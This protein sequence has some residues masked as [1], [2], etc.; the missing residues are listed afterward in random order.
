[1]T[2][3][4]ICIVGDGLAGATAAAA[5]S[6]AGFDCALIGRGDAAG[7][8]VR[9]TALMP[10]TV[11]LLRGCGVWDHAA[12]TAY[13]LERMRIIDGGAVVDFTAEEVGQPALAWNVPN[14]ALRAAGL[15]AADAQGVTRVTGEAIGIQRRNGVATVRLGDGGGIAAELV[16]AAD[17]E[18]SRMRSAAGVSA[19]RWDYGLSALT[20]PVTAQIDP[21]ATSVERYLPT[22]S[23]TTV[24]TGD[25]VSIVWIADHETTAERDALNDWDL[26]KDAAAAVDGDLGD[27]R[28]AGPRARF[29][30][31]GLHAR[32]YGRDGVALI[33]EA[34]HRVP[35]L[36][37]QGFNLTARDVIG[38]R[39]ALLDA[40]R[41]GV[42]LGA[43]AVLSRYDRARRP[44]VTSRI[45]AVD[46]LTR[47]VSAKDGRPLALLRGAG[48][49][50]LGGSAGAIRRLLMREGM[51]P[52]LARYA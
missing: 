14:A 29:P 37:S 50:M 46:A 51:E 9:T 30:L 40:R 7:T 5:L 23:I 2:T 17:G 6:A 28:I 10:E 35:P 21:G 43:S 16:I 27:L 36:G 42:A 48:L 15:A 1:M 34:A 47:F 25:M 18:A 13:P 4:T 8:D 22:G 26:A 39:A 49:R 33:G 12:A 44:D 41:D 3:C 11:S 19:R 20:F 38:L 45:F 52:R 24:P 31:R 32:R